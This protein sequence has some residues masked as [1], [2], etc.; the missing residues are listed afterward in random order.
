MI[1]KKSV[2]KGRV[3]W[4]YYRVSARAG[5]LNLCPFV[6]V[7]PAQCI[8]FIQGC[9]KGVTYIYPARRRDE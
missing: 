6:G 2:D 3:A 5:L 4:Y 8:P 1:D 7:M 9:T